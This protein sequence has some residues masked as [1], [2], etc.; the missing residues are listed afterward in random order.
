MANDFFDKYKAKGGNDLEQI[1]QGAPTTFAEVATSESTPAAA[2]TAGA[3]ADSDAYAFASM[4][5]A[6]KTATATATLETPKAQEM[7][8][9]QS[10]NNGFS[11][12]VRAASATAAGASA[13]SAYDTATRKT[14]FG[15]PV[16]YIG[17]GV[18][19]LLA[20]LLGVLLLGRGKELPDMQGWS[21]S[22]VEM[23]AGE[24]KIN[25][26]AEQIYSDEVSSGSVISQ[27]PA[28]GERVKNGDFLNVTI[29]GGPDLSIMVPVPDVMNMTMAEVEA[30]AD[31]NFM[32]TVRVT[33]Q[34]SETVP[35]GSVISFTINDNTVLTDEIRRDTPF[36][37]VFSKGK[38]AGEAIEVPNFLAM[39]VSEAE[40]FALENK[41]VL[42]IE[43]EFSETVAKGN[44]IRQDIKADETVY[45]GDTITIVV[46]T[47]EEIIVPNFASLSRELAAA[48]ASQLGIQTLVQ[49]SYSTLAEDELI[50]QSTKAG[51]L[52][53]E[54]DII[55][56][57][58][59]KGNQ[60]MITSFVGQSET[61][62]YAWRDGLNKDG[63]S[64][65]VTVTY[66]QSA[67]AYGTVLD[68]SHENVNVGIDAHIYIIAS[69]GEP[70]TVPNFVQ[71][72]GK[73]YDEII[74]KADVI[75]TCD[76]LGIVAYFE[77]GTA[78][79]RLPGEVWYQSIAAGSEMLKGQSIVIK[80]VPASAAANVKVPDFVG[81]TLEQANK[82]S[83]FG[84]LTISYQDESGA[85][86]SAS[87]I[88]ANDTVKAQSVASGSSVK[89]GYAITLTIQAAVV[90]TPAPAPEPTETPTYA[91][92]NFVWLTYADVIATT[93]ADKFDL[94]FEDTNGKQVTTT[95]L[96]AGGSMSDYIVSVQSVSAYGSMPENTI[97]VLTMVEKQS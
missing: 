22:E 19:V 54:D 18:A 69:A 79:N 1:A 45:E 97:I 6:D 59:S 16:L 41:I 46:S 77:E 68:Q 11:A 42:V 28:A 75:A 81:M 55:V 56:L 20:I 3:D 31:D 13:G 33:T 73:G 21:A 58:Y 34:T 82:E 9:E 24:N 60:F 93:D 30:W 35:S 91:V 32:S 15:V 38:P 36:Y 48:K 8:F 86:L 95:E 51:T 64:I 67:Q 10:A 17:I 66:T 70:V 94:K 89:A 84:K 43:E 23:W 74:T 78:T 87:D 65:K 37:V 26:R 4:V 83:A 47:G 29:S 63:A 2:P 14:V 39:S 71:P 27:S 72:A 92:P 40:T 62:V 61:D 76:A 44:V 5:T 52:Y 96:A 50:S 7:R 25:F 49:E 90:A 12:P 85:A 88:G 57:T 53:Q 80:V